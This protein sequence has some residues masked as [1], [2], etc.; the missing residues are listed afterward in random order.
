MKKI[1]KA[2]YREFV[3][4][5]HLLAVGLVCVVTFAALLLKIHL[6]WDFVIVIYLISLA[7]CLSGRYLYIE[8]D[9]LTNPDRSD[10]LNKQSKIAPIII[11]LATILLF[12]T[13]IYVGKYFMIF[14]T[15]ILISLG[16]F[17]DI[18]FKALTKKVI[19]FKNFYVGMLFSSLILML[20]L[21]YQRHLSVAF[22]LVFAYVYLMTFMGASFSDIKD[23]EL[24]RKSNLLTFANVF[25]QKKLLYALSFLLIISVSP[26]V[27]GVF[28][29]LFPVYSLMI[30]LVVPYNLTLFALSLK[31]SFNIDFLYGAVFDSQLIWWLAFLL[32]GRLLAR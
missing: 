29:G 10:Y 30:L 13:I 18:Y 20:M 19:G 6:T 11:S 15:L 7:P 22:W 24:D 3:Y 23:I 16:F 8:E 21:Y 2:I 17:Y 32:L 5:G 25:G 27:I 26:I 1:L 31:K 28:L 12:G 4:G 9:E 14:F